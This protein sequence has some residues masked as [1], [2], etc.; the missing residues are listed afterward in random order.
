M[1]RII[2]DA[3]VQA[4]PCGDRYKLSVV[5][6]DG[7][8]EKVTPHRIERFARACQHIIALKDRRSDTALEG[9]SCPRNELHLHL[10]SLADLAAKTLGLNTDIIFPEEP[11]RQAA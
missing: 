3:F 2:F 9:Y 8:K 10:W 4:K 6:T 1:S 5:L 7:A 11:A